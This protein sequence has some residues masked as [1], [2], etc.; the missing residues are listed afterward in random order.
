MGGRSRSK[1]THVG[2]NSGVVGMLVKNCPGHVAWG[3]VLKQPEAPQGKAG[4]KQNGA[5]GKSPAQGSRPQG[6]VAVE[7]AV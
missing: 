3:Q 1:P 6:G 7:L 4:D 5:H 2:I